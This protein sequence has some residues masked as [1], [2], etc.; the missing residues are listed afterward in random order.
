VEGQM[1]RCVVVDDEKPARDEISFLINSHDQYEVVK[2]YDN[3]K[4]LLIDIMNLDVDVL[5]IDINMPV[6]SGIEVVE[7][8]SQLDLDVHIVFV[9]A[10]DDFAVKAFELH[11]I[12]YIL[13]PVSDERI[14]LCL[15]RILEEKSDV[16]YGQKMQGMLSQVAKDKKDYCCLHRDGKIVP[17]KLNEI[18]YVKAENKG[19]VIET[20]KGQFL[21]S[22]QLGELEKRLMDES[23]FR[24]HRSYLVNLSYILNIEPWFNR[25]YQV[26]LESV[27]EKVPISRHY[28]QSFKDLMNIL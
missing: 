1:I 27:T 3:G 10:Y 25:T 26:E 24:C 15:E 5:F 9:T 19:T 18:I 6:I 14:T 13:K 2:T 12:D 17:V 21:S 7:H 4:S 20:T 22:I 28:V 11:A 8:L 16:S 23:F